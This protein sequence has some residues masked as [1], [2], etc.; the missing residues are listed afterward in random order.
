[1]IDRQ[2]KI[3]LEFIQHAARILKTLGH[4]DRLKIIEFLEEGEKTVGMIHRE[5]GLLQPIASQ[6]LKVM[7]QSGIVEYRQ[8][9]TRYFYRI[10]NDFILKILH[11]M[12]DVQEKIKNGEWSIGF[13]DN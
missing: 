10:A 11:C 5:L 8:E 13:S 4:P 6:H 1:M 9:G 2:T 12:S 3:S 7:Y